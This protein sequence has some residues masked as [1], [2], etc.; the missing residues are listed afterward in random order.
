MFMLQACDYPLR[1]IG[2]ILC[3]LLLRVALTMAA[4][5]LPGLAGREVSDA[6]QHLPLQP[7]LDVGPHVRDYD[8]DPDNGDRSCSI[9]WCS[10]RPSTTACRSAAPAERAYAAPDAMNINGRN[11]PWLL[12]GSR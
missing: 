2:I 3:A 4:H 12:M 6:H 9:C 1:P 11:G 7:E 10:S 5:F 8:V